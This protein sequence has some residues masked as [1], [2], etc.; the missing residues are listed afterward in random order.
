M[1]KSNENETIAIES[2]VQSLLA[3]SD[4]KRNRDYSIKKGRLGIR[5]NPKRDA[6]KGKLATLLKEL[7]P[8]YS[9][10]WETPNVLRWF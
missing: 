2:F 8:E 9:Y 3:L 1:K 10:Y 7:Y 6:I 4:M 5:K